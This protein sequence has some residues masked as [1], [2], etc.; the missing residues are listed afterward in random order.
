MRRKGS[1]VVMAVLLV[2]AGWSAGHAQ[3]TVASF[4][5]GIDAP[6]GVINV[7]CPRGCDWPAEGGRSLPTI[8]F[9]CETERCRFQFNGRGRILLDMPR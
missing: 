2:L 6:R 9:R 3:A 8:T 1:L 4:E 5:I 7:S